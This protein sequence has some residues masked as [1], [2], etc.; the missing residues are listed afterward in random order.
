MMTYAADIEAG[1]RVL[2]APEM[3]ERVQQHDWASTPLGAGETWPQSLRTA[4]DIMLASG[5]AM[6]VIWG[7]ERILLYNDAYAPILGSRHPTALGL[8]TATVWPELWD[9]IRPL[10]DRT[11]AGESCVFREQPLIMT[12]NGFE[13]ETWWDFA[14]SPIRD[15]QGE[16]AGL[17]NVTSDNTER[18]LAL[19]QRDA[20]V[21]EAREREAFMTSV[22]AASTDCIKVIEL[23]GTL[24][25]MSEGGMRVMEVSDFNAVK[26]CPW[27][28]LL[29]SDGPE[30]ARQ[31]IAAAKRGQV[32]HFETAADTYLGT[33]KFWSVSVSP[34]PGADGQVARILSVSRD[35]TELHRS[36]EHQRLLNDELA[37]RI[38]NTMSVIQA[39]AFQTLG[40]VADKTSMKAF[41]D[42][43]AALS[44]SHNLLTGQSWSAARF[45]DLARLALS[46]FGEER[47]MLTGP[48][49][50]IGPRAGL[51]LSLMLHELATNAVKYGALSVPEGNVRLN[52]EVRPSDQ[53]DKDTLY[54]RWVERGG[55]PAVEPTRKGFGSKV[56]RMGLTGSGG[57]NI[58]Y[59]EEGLTVEASAPLYQVQEA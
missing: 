13:E 10:I 40:K 19:R 54:L 46:T 7:P 50:D 38:K 6:C 23:D 34:I 41:D 51:S 26:G 16:V 43:L 31:A 9:D 27:P 24:S 32:S 20:V 44:A 58:H 59:G 14:Y 47:F 42:R 45:G 12:R 36:R 2:V 29:K 52:W 25:F 30:H 55:P 8:S 49:L 1:K 4:V 56:I 53:A 48:A 35:L 17:L 39:I 21:A 37:H 33:G 3:R 11:F 15:E 18:V 57:V 28:D 22:L 5:H